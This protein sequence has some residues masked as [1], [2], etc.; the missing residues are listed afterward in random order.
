MPVLRED[1]NTCAGYHSPTNGFGD[2]QPI[3]I[4]IEKSLR[5]RITPRGS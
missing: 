1:D 2:T 3:A 4:G 5:T